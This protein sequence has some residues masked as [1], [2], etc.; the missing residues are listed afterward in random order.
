MKIE[1]VVTPAVTEVVVVTPESTEYILR[2]SEDEMYILRAYLGASAPTSTSV[3]TTPLY[4]T[5]MKALG[6][7]DGGKRR[8]K[9]ADVLNGSPQGAIIRI[10]RE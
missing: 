9:V 7:P 2:C 3:N 10:V 6:Y 5:I 8:Y 4:E 1:K